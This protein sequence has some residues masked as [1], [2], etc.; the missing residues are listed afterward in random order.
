MLATRE[1]ML[2]LHL[3]GSVSVPVLSQST[4]HASQLLYLCQPWDT[5]PV[6]YSK[7]ELKILMVTS[8]MS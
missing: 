2:N 3:Q 8:Q 7:E 4:K 1:M 5:A 6:H